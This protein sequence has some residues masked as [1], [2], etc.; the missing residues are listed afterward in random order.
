MSDQNFNSPAKRQPREDAEAGAEPG[1]R[2]DT[3]S[4]TDRRQ[5]NAQGTQSPE[6]P[7]QPASRDSL[8]KATSAPPDAD[9]AR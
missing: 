8:E 7:S 9:P 3:L 2:S 5:Q 6:H 1:H 4:D